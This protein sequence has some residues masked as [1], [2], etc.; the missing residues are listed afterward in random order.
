MSERNDPLGVITAILAVMCNIINFPW[1]LWLASEEIQTGFGYGTN[2]EMAALFP[3]MTELLSLPFIVVGIV[4]FVTAI[5]KG[6][7]K[8]FLKPNVILYVLLIFQ[9]TITNLFMWI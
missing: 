3:W 8:R 6:K 5:L 2:I 9:I 7:R 1:T 4:Y